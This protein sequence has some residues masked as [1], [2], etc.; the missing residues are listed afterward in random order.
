MLGMDIV[1]EQNFEA[2]SSFSAYTFVNSNEKMTLELISAN[3]ES[4][5]PRVT[6]KINKQ[7]QQIQQTV[8]RLHERTAVLILTNNMG[9]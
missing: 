3:E 4:R 1:G 9:A 7:L 6:M 5:Y 2:V 8:E